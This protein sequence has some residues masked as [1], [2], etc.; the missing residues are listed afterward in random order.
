MKTKSRTIYQEHIIIVAWNFSVVNQQKMKG[1]VSAFGKGR[2]EYMSSPLI[3]R[4]TS[5]E[6]VRARD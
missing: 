4:V 2:G 1:Q 3:L 5:V 6:D